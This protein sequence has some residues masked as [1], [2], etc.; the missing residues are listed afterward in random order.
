MI[1]DHVQDAPDWPYSKAKTA[2][3]L[4]AAAV[5]REQGPR[6]ATLKNIAHR[7]GITEPAIFRHFDGVDGLF[8]GLFSVCERFYDKASEIYARAEPGIEGYLGATEEVL[9]LMASGGDFAYLIIHS[10]QVFSGYEEFRAKAKVLR[11]HDQ[12]FGMAGLT[13]V[14][15]RGEIRTGAPVETIGLAFM[16]IIH[17]STVSWLESDLAFDL[18]EVAGARLRSFFSLIAS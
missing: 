7:A 9:R 6:S 11:A 18:A 17:M 13:Q 16:G 15:E 1:L 10:L 12:R 3:L 14:M 4:A 2:V 5:I 8:A